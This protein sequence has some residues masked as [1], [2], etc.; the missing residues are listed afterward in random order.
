MVLF[1]RLAVC[2]RFYFMHI[3]MRSAIAAINTNKALN[4]YIM[5]IGSM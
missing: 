1:L 2:I 5:M 3:P 4:D